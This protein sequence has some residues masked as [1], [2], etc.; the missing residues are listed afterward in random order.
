MDPSFR[1]LRSPRN[2]KS[3]KAPG[4]YLLSRLSVGL[5]IFA[6]LAMFTQPALAQSPIPT[7]EGEERPPEAPERVEIEPAAQ[8]E[9][10]EERLA[11]ILQATGWFVNPDV[12]VREG[13]VFLTGRTESE[14]FKDWAGNLA[15]NTQDVAAVVNQI[16]IIQPSIWN[17]EPA[18]NGLSELWRGLL[19]AIPLIVFSLLILVVTFFAARY[20]VAAAR[21]SLKERLPSPL[22]LRNAARAVGLLVFLIGLYVVFQV[23]GLTSVA[24]TILGGTGLLGLILGIAFQDITENFLASIVL[25]IQSPFETGDLVDIGGHTGFVQA[26]TTRVT[27]LMSQDGNHVQIPNGTVYKS[28][29]QNFTSNPNRRIDFTVGIGFE[30][31]ISDAQEVALR[32]LEEHP[33]VLTTPEP[34][35]LVESLGSATV[36]LRVYFWLDGNQ[37]SWL[38]VKSSVI[39]LV[40][41]AFL[42]EGISMPDEAREMLFPEGIQVRMIEAKENGQEV[43]PMPRTKPQTAEESASVSTDAEDGLSS[44]AGEIEEQARRSRTPEEGEDLLNPSGSS[45]R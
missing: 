19:R 10:I 17:I 30:D 5:L 25:S 21:A 1:F 37:H 13:V 38:K 32:V 26:L 27:V 12:D 16:E 39:R 2:Q 11:G 41:R 14:E 22:L 6:C 31:S 34:W 42:K 23:A 3:S 35:V 29:I 28:T 8:D 24:L 15:R 33:A 4:Y 18:V 7:P 20:S 43:A 45:G 44:D 40:K 36:N 9:E